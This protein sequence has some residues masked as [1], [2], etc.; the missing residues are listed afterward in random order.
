M[1]RVCFALPILVLLKNTAQFGV[2]AE[3]AEEMQAKFDAAVEQECWD[4]AQLAKKLWN[5]G[6]QVDMAFDSSWTKLKGDIKGDVDHL[7]LDYANKFR[8]VG[9]KCANDW[10]NDAPRCEE[11]WTKVLNEYEQKTTDLVNNE[12]ADKEKHNTDYLAS[13]KK[14]ETDM[15]NNE[16]KLQEKIAK[17]QAELDKNLAKL[18]EDIAAD[19]KKQIEHEIQEQQ[20]LM[21]KMQ[22]KM[23]KF[24]TELGETVCFE[25]IG[26]SR[27]LYN[28]TEVPIY[29]EQL[30]K[31]LRHACAEKGLDIEYKKGSSHVIDQVF[32]NDTDARLL[33]AN[34]MSHRRLGTSSNQVTSAVNFCCSRCSGDGAAGDGTRRRLIDHES[35]VLENRRRLAFMDKKFM[36][37]M[38]IK[39]REAFEGLESVE[40]CD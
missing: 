36:H 17:L 8:N 29:D 16:I 2:A 27:K 11:E 40:K 19:L 9:L 31:A 20:K 28:D 15:A 37:F 30:V 38:T 10:V 22:K 26:V 35:I 6:I 5:D 25:Y 12:E 21:E 33:R 18:E 13:A 32:T 34:H 1:S 4:A 23:L 3:T 39:L 14:V 24:Q 7:D